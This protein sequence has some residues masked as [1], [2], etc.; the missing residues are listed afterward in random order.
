[1][2]SKY[3][4]YGLMQSAAADAMSRPRVD[5]LKSDAQWLVESGQAGRETALSR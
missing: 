4:F 1:V 5:F 2:S 3:D